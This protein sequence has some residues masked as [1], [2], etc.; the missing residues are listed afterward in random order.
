MQIPLKKKKINIEISILFL[1][2]ANGLSIQGQFYQYEKCIS[3]ALKMQKS[4]SIRGLRTVDPDQRFTL[5]P[6]GGGGLTAPSNPQ[7]LNC[8]DRTEPKNYR[9]VLASSER[10]EV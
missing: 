4:V 1:Y 9:E 7:L 5:Y 8:N 2:S 6:R 10:W 3:D